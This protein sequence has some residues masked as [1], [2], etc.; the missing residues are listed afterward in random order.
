MV[1]HVACSWSGGKDSCYALM[2]AKAAGYVPVVLLNVMN[3]KG[4][5]S[6][7]HGLPERVLIQQARQMNIPLVTVASSWKD[8][9]MH[10]INSLK[11]LRD[12][13]DLAGMVFGDIDLQEHRDWEEKVCAAA[14]ITALLPLW[15]RER[16]AVATE[17]VDRGIAA[18]IVSCKAE[19]GAAFCGKAFDPALIRKL[20]QRE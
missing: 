6:R 13:Y 19:L 2:L 9:E 17:M 15:Q 10:F 14:G 16:K 20:E 7:S 4:R 5:I 18:R 12:D 11:K 3:E 8:Y 1:K